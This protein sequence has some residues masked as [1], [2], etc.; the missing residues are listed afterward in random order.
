MHYCLGCQ[1]SAEDGD[2]FGGYS[3][4]ARYTYG[5]AAGDSVITN[6]RTVATF[7]FAAGGQPES[8][9]INPDGSLTVSL[10]GLLTGQPPQLVHIS[11]TGARTVLV[12]GQAGEAIGGNVRDR[13]GTIYYNMLSADPSRSGL[14]RLPPGGSPERIGALPAGAFLNGLTIDAAGENLY[15]ADS[16]AGTIWTVPV[17]GGQVK[18]WLTDPAL[19]PAVSGPGHFGVNGVTFHEGAV[20]ASNTDRATLLRIPVTAAGAPGSIR[21]V[22]GGLTGIDDFK[23]LSDCSDVAFAALNSAN[24]FAAVYPDGR[25]KIVLTAADGL[26]SPTNTAI[27]GNHIYITDG[28]N[29]APHDAKLQEGTINLAALLSESV[30]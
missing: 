16:L 20:W 13:Q 23:F 30:V 8:L 19:A 7:D 10:L 14:W 21:V 15:A 25:T 17:W 28:G 5:G 24:E 4:Q 2:V 9:T 22:A 12:T 3:E 1:R 11:R 6:L 18:A 26:D 29:A 27:R